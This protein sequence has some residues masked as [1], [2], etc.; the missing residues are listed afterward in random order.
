V[1]HDAILS[2]RQAGKAHDSPAADRTRWGSDAGPGIHCER[3]L[4]FERPGDFVV[5]SDSQ[6]C[7]PVFNRTV[8][9]KDAWAKMRSEDQTAHARSA[10]LDRTTETEDIT[11]APGSL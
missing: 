8:T 5:D 9:L 2:L 10:R 7:A 3:R 1:A 6:P 11:S 4:S